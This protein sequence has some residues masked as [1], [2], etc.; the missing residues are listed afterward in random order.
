MSLLRG[1]RHLGGWAAVA[2][3]LLWVGATRTSSA[4]VPQGKP[5][6]E[7]PLKE[8]HTLGPQIGLPRLGLVGQDEGVLRVVQAIQDALQLHSAS[9]LFVVRGDD[10]K[11]AVQDA[12]S[13]VTFEDNKETDAERKSRKAS[14]KRWLFVY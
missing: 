4:P 1:M 10:L 9:N 2:A 11:A 13:W 3:G 7:I 12:R 14:N 5:E 8:I 6:R